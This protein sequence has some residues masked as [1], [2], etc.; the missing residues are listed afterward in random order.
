MKTKSPAGKPLNLRPFSSVLVDG[1][2]RAAAR[3]MLY[4]VGFT[5]DDFK[6]PIIGIAS[7][8]SNFTPCNMHIDKLA[9]EA[10]KGADEGGG[11]AIIFNTITISDGISMGS[12]GMKYSLV[13]REVIADSIETVVGCGGMDGYV[14][15]GGCDKNM[16]GAMIC[17]ARMN[18]PAVFVYGGTIL[19]GCIPGDPQKRMLDIV[20]VF[21]AVGR[22]AAGMID[23]AQLKTVEQCA[24]PGPGSC[25][26]MYTANT[27]ASAIEAL[28]MSLPNSS[29]QNAISPAKM[30]DCR[31]A[32]AAVVNM[33]RKGIKP[34]DILTKK[35]FENA[36]TVVIALGGSTNAVLHLLAIA[37]AAKV[38]LTLDDFTRIGKRVPVLADLKPSGKHLMSELVAVGGIRPIMK[39]LLDHGLLHGDCLTVTGATMAET[40][41]AAKPYPAW[42]T[43]IQ[44]FDKPIKKDSHLV[45]FRGNLA[46][47]GAVGKIS[48]KEGLHF[49][50]KAI[51]FEG[52]EAA[53]KAI[54]NGTVKKGHVVVVRGEGPKG[55]PGMREMLSPTS[56]IMG[57]GLG[58]EV[59]LITDGRFSGGSHGFVVGHVTPEACVGGPIALVRN[60]DPIL[61]DAGKRELTLQI[62][63]REIAARHKAWRKPAPRYTRGVLAK[64]AAHVTSASLGAVTD[65]DLDL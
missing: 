25:G 8:W 60:G 50:G 61:I 39:T 23:D 3:A 59:A 42:Q 46:P 9:L 26:G 29:A 4:P 54:L 6:K 27:M 17:I 36:I 34:L 52:E 13:S 56:A 65:A 63:A 37:H 48:G 40:L 62:S 2:E 20:S 15:I 24:I 19:P 18:R 30:D 64:Y 53:L 21:E 35:A 49:E 31:R 43:I 57:R 1:P 7:T 10:A 44:P 55:G 12:E 22:R 33:L 47:E 32:G 28:G 16:P 51:V 41:A 38:K 14:A 5:E 45:I 58:K 11:K